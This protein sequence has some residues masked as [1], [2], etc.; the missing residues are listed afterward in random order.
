MTEIV[1]LMYESPWSTIAF[2]FAAGIASYASLAGFAEVIR[3]GR[4]HQD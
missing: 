2:F 3:A 1:K 4:K